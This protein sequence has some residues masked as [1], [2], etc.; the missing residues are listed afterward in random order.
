[1]ST[2]T[3]YIFTSGTCARSALYQLIIDQLT[4]AG[5]TNVASL[6]SSDFVVMKSTSNTGD[7]NLL[8]NIRDSSSTAVNPTTT[9]DYCVMSYRLQDTYVPGA[10]GV[11]GV[12]G[13]PA[14]AWTNLFL[15]PSDD[16]TWKRY[17]L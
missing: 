9:T 4:A 11:A 5:W 2:P 15:A 12:F 10:A 7:K 8:L 6:A 1:M 3:D 17:N 14:L 13:R 16:N